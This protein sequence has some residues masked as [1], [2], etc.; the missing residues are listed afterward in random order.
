MKQESKRLGSPDLDR[1][2]VTIARAGNPDVAQTLSRKQIDVV[3]SASGSGWTATST[4]R[5]RQG[6]MRAGVTT[7]GLL[8]CALS[9]YI[10]WND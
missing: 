8:C 5:A 2:S 7:S 6:A 4:G 10:K 3:R 1:H 9:A